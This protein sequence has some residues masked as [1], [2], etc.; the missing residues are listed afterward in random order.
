MRYEVN[1]LSTSDD[2]DSIISQLGT[3]IS[4][5]NQVGAVINVSA[6]TA[7]DAI[8]NNEDITLN[9]Y[10]VLVSMFNQAEKLCF[11]DSLSYPL[12]K[13]SA[14]SN[15]DES[16][17]ITFI[18]SLYGDYMVLS[19][20]YSVNSTVDINGSFK[21]KEGESLLIKSEAIQGEVFLVTPTTINHN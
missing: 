11:N 10:P 12:L 7:I 9:T 16:P 3:Q 6:N 19:Y 14:A 5:N 8:G 15:I 13:E 21:V 4:S 2:W 17:C 20:S 1:K 18:T